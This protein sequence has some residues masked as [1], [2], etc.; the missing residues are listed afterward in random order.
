M[1]F[2]SKLSSETSNTTFNTLCAISLAEII[3]KNKMIDNVIK[4]TITY[5]SLTWQK[6]MKAWNLKTLL[7]FNASYLVF[8]VLLEAG[9]WYKYAGYLLYGL[10]K[11]LIILVQ[12]Q[13]NDTSIKQSTKL[14][15]QESEI[16]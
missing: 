15:I 2:S 3:I 13:L 16:F 14:E 9:T 5:K 8:N 4:G 1:K 6:D 12:A 10:Y 11:I 7:M